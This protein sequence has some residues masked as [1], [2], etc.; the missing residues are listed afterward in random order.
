MGVAGGV[1]EQVGQHLD[2][3][4]PVRRHPGQTRRKVDDQVAATAPD[5]EPAPG[6]IHQHGDLHRFRG[7]RQ[8]AGLDAGHVQQVADQVAHA[9]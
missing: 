6:L 5:L 1:G 9:L 2:H 7:Y 8:G 3:P 4:P